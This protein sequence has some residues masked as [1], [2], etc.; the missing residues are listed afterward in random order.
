M[1]W[2]EK[3]YARKMIGELE[4]KRKLAVTHGGDVDY[5]TRLI[6]SWQGYLDNLK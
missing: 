2:H 5:F 6:A 1:K 3:R 4:A